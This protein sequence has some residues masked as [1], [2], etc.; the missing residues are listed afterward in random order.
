[1]STIAKS[2]RRVITPILSI[3]ISVQGCVMI[4]GSQCI[5]K[6]LYR[7]NPNK[8]QRYIDHTETAFVS[9]IMSILTIFAPSSVRITTEKDSIPSGSIIKD[10]KKRR[11]ISKL[12]PNSVM[13]ANHQIYT[14][15]IFLWWLCYTSDLAGNVVIML[16]E[17]LSKIPVIGGGMKNYNFIF[18]KR[19][20]ENDKVTMNKYLNNMNENSFG[21]GPIA[22]EVIKHK[23]CKDQEVI[24]WPY[25]L[26]LF[27]EGTNL[28]KNTRS[29]SDRYAKKI[30]RKGFECCLLPHATGLYYS[31]ESL[32]P[33]L[34]VVYDVTI[35]YSGVKKHEYGE[36]IYTMKNIFLEGKP[37]KLVDIHIRAFKL[38]EIPLDSIE[39][40]TEW[41]FKVW[42]EK[43]QRLIKYYETGHFGSDPSLSD[44]IIDDFKINSSEVAMVM[45]LPIC[46]IIITYLFYKLLF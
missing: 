19:H 27:P 34:D 32:K 35:G 1:M 30:D 46:G 38:N 29:K 45:M 33:S 25:C 18:L 16:K 42:Q 43:D 13:I 31:L 7:N 22:K 39:E 37:P 4:F 2:I 40:F 14:D 20:W 44:Q 24:R 12:L 5:I 11:I 26:L 15:W 36:L 23:E 41:L 21:T 28:S 3:I 10:P 17:S 6:L 9:L 8:R